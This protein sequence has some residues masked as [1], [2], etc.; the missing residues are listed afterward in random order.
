[1][2]SVTAQTL[3]IGLE[4]DCCDSTLPNQLHTQLSGGGY[5]WPMSV[6]PL[7]AHPD[8]Y[9][10]SLRTARKRAEKARRL[11]YQFDVFERC[12]YERD[13]NDIN[14]SRAVRQ[15]RPMADAYMKRQTFSPIGPQPCRRHFVAEYGVFDPFDTLV[16]YSIVIRS[17]ELA[18]VSQILGH[19]DHEHR[20]IMQLLGVE[21]YAHEYP[22]GGFLVYNRHDSGGDG[23]RQAKEWLR[24][25]PMRIEWQQ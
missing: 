16:A 18:L 8:E 12:D 2:S 6:I 25:Q 4:A 7:T 23:L 21:I 22:Q 11:G 15:G 19:G 24:Y 10:Q 3:Q 9:V 20:G 17:G 13:V 1:M 14:Q 5:T